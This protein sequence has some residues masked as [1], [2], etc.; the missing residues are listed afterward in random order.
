M[1][2]LWI[3]G[4]SFS[5]TF[6]KE[7]GGIY[8]DWK[9]NYVEFKGYT[10]KVFGDIVAEKLN[11]E[12]VNTNL[13]GFATDNSTILSRIIEHCDE[14]KDGDVISVGW[15]ALHRT[16]VV[17]FKENRWAVITPN[18]PIV[19]FPNFSERTFQEIGVNRSHRL[20]H[21]ELCDWVKLV[22]RLFKNN[23]VIQW[24]WT[25]YSFMNFQSIREETNGLFID[26]HWSE[27]GHEEF[28][29]WFIDCHKNNNCI[30]F[31]KKK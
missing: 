4:D 24:T 2:K 17:N 11:L 12:L 26:D 13:M 16:R 25:Q 8:L 10:P 9:K 6:K 15:T 18:H 27:K 21:N 29:E 22:D 31:F 19:D 28:A 5:E 1:R 14:V 20:Y 7:N 30:D 3:F 23:K